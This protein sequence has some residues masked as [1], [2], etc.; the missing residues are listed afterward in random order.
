MNSFSFGNFA[1]NS[2]RDFKQVIVD[3]FD[4]YLSPIVGMLYIK[5]SYN[6]LKFYCG[7]YLSF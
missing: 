4:V 7:I 3:V 6:V 5:I 2:H 1:E